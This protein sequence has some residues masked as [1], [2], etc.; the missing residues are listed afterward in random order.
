MQGPLCSGR[1]G[2]WAGGLAALVALGCASPGPPRLPSLHLPGL[3]TRVEAQRVG[4]EV[5]LTWLTPANTT[6]GDRIRGQITAVICRER[7][8][9]HA[10][11]NAPAP[12]C[13]PIQRLAVAPGPGQAVDVLPP[14]L[15]TGAPALLAYRIELLNDR[16]RSAGRGDAAYAAAGEAPAPV[17][18]LAISPRREST[19]I[20]W[21]EVSPQSSAAA[22]MELRR[23]LIATAEGREQPRSLGEKPAAL[24]SQP[25]D[26]LKASGQT[27]FNASKEPAAEV[28]LTVEA[29][30]RGADPGGT[31]DR[32]VRDGEHYL[33]VA[34]RVRKVTL[35]GQELE[36]R[37]VPSAPAAFAYR[38][39]FPPRVPLELVSAPGGGFGVAPSIDLSWEPNAE[40][41]LLGYNVYRRVASG[42][43]AKL[44][45]EPVPSSAFR[46][47]QVSPGHT[48]EYRVTALDRRHNESAPSGEIHV[49]LKE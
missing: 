30:G 38:D 3:A 32:T 7:V 28:T 13:D 36:L 39:T 47:M 41:D 8:R 12:P 31:L 43:F 21:Q 48:Y 34:Q 17:R 29:D 20:R 10:G 18:S 26:P 15:S 42:A 23:T 9:L 27:P 19:L 45:G 16:V 2:G 24:T 33:Y 11:T 46:D 5:R 14:N 35:S 37:G 25:K 44:N 40:S 1:T 22:V 6:D 49:S 4:S